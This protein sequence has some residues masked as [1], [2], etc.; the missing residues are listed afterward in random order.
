MGQAS[1]VI[2]GPRQVHVKPISR[3]PF[4][5]SSVAALGEGQVAERIHLRLHVP[6]GPLFLPVGA[7]LQS[8]ATAIEA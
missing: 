4:G 3:A 2:P 5:G 7:R 1:D 6:L 8:P